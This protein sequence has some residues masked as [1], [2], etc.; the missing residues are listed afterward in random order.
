MSNLLLTW[1]YEPSNERFDVCRP[2]GQCMRLSNATFSAFL[3]TFMMLSSL[4]IFE[5]PNF[6]DTE[7]EDSSQD[8]LLSTS[9]RNSAKSF[10]VSGGSSTQS[11][12]AEYIDSNPTGGWVIGSTFCLLYTSPSPRDS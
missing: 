4:L 1:F 8:D 5:H 9:A 10:L 11:I 6:T 12:D 3:L 7:L 2:L